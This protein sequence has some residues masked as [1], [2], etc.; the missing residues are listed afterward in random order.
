LIIISMLTVLSSNIFAATPEI[1]TKCSLIERASG[2]KSKT[3]ILDITT[4]G[5]EGEHSIAMKTQ[6]GIDTDALYILSLSKG[7]DHLDA[8]NEVSGSDYYLSL[9]RLQDETK[10]ENTKTLKGS[11]SDMI[12]IQVKYDSIFKTSYTNRKGKH[13]SGV[14]KSLVLDYKLSRGKRVKLKCEIIS[15]R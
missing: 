2:L 1:T 14:P 3:E 6:M 8:T 15:I 12:F 9:S 7:K 5:A 11:L 10:T 4:L 13:I